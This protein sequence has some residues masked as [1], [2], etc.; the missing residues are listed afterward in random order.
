MSEFL[1]QIL[2]QGTLPKVEADLLLAGI[3][4][5]TKRFTHN[6]GVR[7]FPRRFICAVREQVLSTHRRSLR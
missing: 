6:T 7:T 2:P 1:E 5:D 3:L 4:L